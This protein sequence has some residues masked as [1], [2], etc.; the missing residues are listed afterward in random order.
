MRNLL[1]LIL[2]SLVYVGATT[3]QTTYL[4]FETGVDPTAYPFG[5]SAFESGV[6]NPDATGV[7]VSQKVGKTITGVETWAGMALPIGGSVG[8]SQTSNTITMDVYSDVTGDVVFKL[9]NANN[10]SQAVELTTAYTTANAWET[11]TFEFGDTLEADVYTQ[12]V[13]FFNFGTSDE[14]T[15]YFDNVVGPEANFSDDVDVNLIINDKLGMANTVALN[16]EGEDVA[17]TQ[18]GNLWTASKLMA[19]YNIVE[20]GGDYEAIVMVDSEPFDTATIT[21]AGGQTTMDWNYLLLNEDEEDGTALAISVG[22]T[23][24][25]IDGTIDDV[26]GNAKVHPL[27]QRDWWGTP[28]GLYAYFKIMWDVTNVYVLIDVDDNTLFNGGGDPWENDN[29]EMFFDM[30]QSASDGYDANDFQIRTIWN[31]DT[32][33]GSPNVE[34]EGWSDNVS[35]AQTTKDGDT[36]YIIEWAIPWASLSTSFLPVESVEFNFDMA[37]ADVADGVGRDYIVSWSTNED[38][39]Y[40]NTSLFGTVTLSNKTVEVGIDRTEIE[41]LS[42]YPN[43]VNDNLYVTAGVNISEIT[44]HDITGRVISSSIVN[45]AKANINVSSL[46]SGIYILRITDEQGNVSARKIKVQ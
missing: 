6:D 46:T 18:D 45:A 33:T 28:T 23:P 26:W 32:F 27:Q 20:G 34:A 24:P 14:T 13:L 41:N 36:G 38:I 11:L 21:V 31:K 12:F 43:P 15:W 39:A 3:A 1:L 22:D 10:T 29:A 30:D 35:R 19:P 8:F 40:K 9:E 2:F 44:V 16:I 37:V 5:G 4:D 25:T 7:N 17:L 42:V